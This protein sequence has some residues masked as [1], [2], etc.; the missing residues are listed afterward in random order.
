MENVYCCVFG[1]RKI[2]ASI[3]LET[4]LNEIFKNLIINKKVNYFLF[5]G[6]GEFDDLCHK[7]ITKLKQQY[8]NIKR[9]YVCEDYK[10]I[11]RPQKRP[12][13]LTS[14][15]YEDFI[16]F[17]TRYTGFYQRIYF[18]NVE[19]INS[20]DYCVFYV[21]GNQKYS[22][23]QKIFDYAVKKKKVLFNVFN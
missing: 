4:K 17:E 12:K 8:A 21:S 23:A 13:W 5:G 7:I 6:F 18:R 22:G 15:D 11:S 20:S 3:K 10:F 1:H 19:I 9:I 2:E 16:Y 14:E